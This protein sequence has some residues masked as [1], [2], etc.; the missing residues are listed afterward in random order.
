M[1][2]FSNTNDFL[3][4]IVRTQAMSRRAGS[5]LIQTRVRTFLAQCLRLRL[6]EIFCARF[7]C[8]RVRYRWRRLAVHSA[9]RAIVG[10]YRTL[11]VLRLCTTQLASVEESGACDGARERERERETRQRRALRIL[12]SCLCERTET[13]GRRKYS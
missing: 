13:H 7:V 5:V 10:W 11:K 9:V 12:P 8:D 1:K 3:K 6:H 2:S 4:T